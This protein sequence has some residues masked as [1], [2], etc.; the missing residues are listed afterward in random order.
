[1][2]DP[3]VVPPALSAEQWR[4]ALH[5][6]IERGFPDEPDNPIEI[7][8]ALNWRSEAACAHGRYEEGIAFANAALP[9]DSPYKITRR[10][11]ELLREAGEALPDYGAKALG[12]L[13]V[14][15]AAKLHALL[16]PESQ[17]GNA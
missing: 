8:N 16:P 10:D 15:L 4:D 7:A 13:L 6:Q 17:E 3:L 9:D 14:A 1:M 12:D 11:V 5:P 2:S